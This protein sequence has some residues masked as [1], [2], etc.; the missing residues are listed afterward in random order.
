MIVCG[1][2]ACFQTA[3]SVVSSLQHAGIETLISGDARA[4]HNL[5]QEMQQ[6]LHQAWPGFVS[7]L[8]NWRRFSEY[9]AAHDKR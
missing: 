2:A 4:G 8:P 3:K 1:S 6:A 5:N 7:G 9:L